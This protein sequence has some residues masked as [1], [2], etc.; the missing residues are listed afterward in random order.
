MGLVDKKAWP[1]ARTWAEISDGSF[2]TNHYWSPKYYS[3]CRRVVIQKTG[4][5]PHS[6][7]LPTHHGRGQ[8]LDIAGTGKLLAQS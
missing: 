2:S 6:P 5:Q 4:V 7:C 1:G 3:E 8:A